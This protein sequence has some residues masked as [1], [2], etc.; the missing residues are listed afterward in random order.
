[1]KLFIVHFGYDSI[2]SY[3]LGPYS[4][5][6]T[7]FSNTS[8]LCSSSHMKDNFQIHIKDLVKF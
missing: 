8:S 1:M 6:N 5:L 2:T 4:H 3:F 7:L